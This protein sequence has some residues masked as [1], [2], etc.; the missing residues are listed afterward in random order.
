MDFT[1]YINSKDIRDYHRKINYQYTA[2][3]AS[4]LVYRCNSVTT[5]EKY[6]AWNWIADN[7]TDQKIDLQKKIGLPKCNLH[8]LLKK[9]MRLAGADWICKLERQVG[10]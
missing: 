4:W 3:E 1:K 9:Y 2:L 5:D 10:F 6:Y 8:N 7:M